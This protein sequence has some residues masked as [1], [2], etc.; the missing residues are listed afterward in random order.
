MLNLLHP[1]KM[2][3]SVA[4][5][6]SKINTTYIFQYSWHWPIN[7]IYSIIRRVSA[8]FAVQ[9]SRTRWIWY[10]IRGSWIRKY[11]DLRRVALDGHLAKTFGVQQ[12]GLCVVFISFWHASCR[13]ACMGMILPGTNITLLFLRTHNHFNRDLKAEL[14]NAQPLSSCVSQL[15]QSLIILTKSLDLQGTRVFR[16]SHTF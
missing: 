8:C 4:L 10:Y 12:D 1:G 6:K 13:F 16:M 9:Y 7:Y 15:D 14:A 2:V 11:T 3:T 5:L